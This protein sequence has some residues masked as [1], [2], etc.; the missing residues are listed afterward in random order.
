[1]VRGNASKW[2]ENPAEIIRRLYCPEYVAGYFRGMTGSKEALVP[3]A[4]QIVSAVKFVRMH[5]W[6]GTVSGLSAFYNTG[7]L[8]KVDMAGMGLI[9]EMVK[10]DVSLGKDALVEVWSFVIDAVVLPDPEMDKQPDYSTQYL[11]T[12]HDLPHVQAV[13]TLF[14]VIL[15]A[16]RNNME[17][18]KVALARIAQ[19]IRLTGQYGIDYHACIDSEALLLHWVDPDWFEQNEQYPGSNSALTMKENLGI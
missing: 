19:A 7:E 8:M 4:D 1:M 10:N 11:Y 5:Q 15:Y 16:K 12:V 2:V 18:S 3:N 6:D 17:V 9:E 13:H 14:E